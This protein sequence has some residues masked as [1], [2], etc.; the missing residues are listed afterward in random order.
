MLGVILSILKT[1]GLILLILVAVLLALILLILLLPVP[2]QVDIRGGPDAGGAPPVSVKI[3]YIKVFPQKQKEPG[4][5]GRR[6]RRGK[7]AGPEEPAVNAREAG[8]GVAA[9]GG[10]GREPENTAEKAI[11]QSSTGRSADAASGKVAGPASEPSPERAGSED[12]KAKKKPR[13]KKAGTE[14]SAKRDIRQAIERVKAEFCDER[15]RGALRRI[16]KELGY[17]MRHYGPRKIK[18]DAEFSLGD[19][20]NTGLATA[21]LSVCPFAYGA[22]CRI[23]PDFD[24]E[25]AYVGGW[26]EA[27]GHV[28]AVHLVIVVARLIL[29]GNIRYVI[30]KVLKFI[31]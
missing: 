10:D 24:S 1:A 29:D 8:D 21:A 20:A 13:G 27:K 30:R 12:K 22:S 4:S 7:S 5:G 31:K 2:Y 15:N 9:G 3:F 18:A 19:P 26:A 25:K 16:F 28:R 17:I 14:K 6:G 11:Q 23:V